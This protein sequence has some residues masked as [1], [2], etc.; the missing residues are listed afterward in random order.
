MNLQ[1]LGQTIKQK[2]P[3]YNNIDDTV[4]ANKILEKYPEYQSK[5]TVETTKKPEQST[6]QKVSSFVPQMSLGVAKGAG[7]TLAGASSLGE[8]TLKGIGRIIT[9]KS[10]EEKLGFAKSPTGAESLG[11]QEKLKPTN[12]AQKIGFGVEQVGE[13]LVPGAT[14]LKVGKAIQGARTLA[15]TPKLAKVAG[16]AGRSLTE[17]GLFG[18]Q[19][20][21]Q[22]GEI[23]DEAKRAALLGGAF[24]VVGT[25]LKIVGQGIKKSTPK[26]A[27][28]IINSMI[29]P[30]MKDLSYE[31]NP[32]RGLLKYVEPF[33][34]F[35]QGMKNTNKSLKTLKDEMNV[36]LKD[37]N[38]LS[39]KIS[40]NKEINNIF[41]KAIQDAAKKNEKTLINRLIENKKAI[42]ENLSYGVNELTG[43]EE[44]ISSGIKNLTK[45]NPQE[46]LELKQIVGEMRK[47]TGN[48]SEDTVSNKSIGKVYGILKEKFIEAGKKHGYDFKEISEGMSDLITAKKVMEYRDKLQSRQNLIN[49]P[50][51]IGIG[52]GAIA[53]IFTGGLSGILA[54][55]TSIGADKVLSSPAFKTRFAKWLYNA[56][57]KEKETLIS[58]F[59]PLKSFIDRAIGGKNNTSKNIYSQIHKDTTTAITTKID[60]NISSIIPKN[61][62]LSRTLSPKFTT[63]SLSPK[64]VKTD[65]LTT[66]IQKAKAEGKSF[67]EWV[68]VKQIDMI[69]KSNPM[70]DDYHTGIRTVKDIKTFR[71]AIDDPESFSYPDF[72]KQKAQQAL[73]NGKITIYSSKEL[74]NPSSQFVSPSKMNATDYAGGNN[75]YSRKVNVD[76]VAWL[77][78]DEGQFIGETKS[79]L[80]VKWD[81]AQVNKKRSLNNL[82]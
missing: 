34:N 57:T 6:L 39:E 70:T 8:K 12:T 21:L 45:L 65:P 60:K 29:K 19:T 42:T 55:I 50:G 62:N 24:P 51:K 40:V 43:K 7:S 26:V 47:W 46:V 23:G 27:E 2:Y 9:P 48:V 78:G 53:S 59:P 61:K 81:K 68:K 16:L 82:K 52:M 72:N 75:V 41:N 5:I 17:A 33:N 38:L 73:D 64:T 74:N 56:S 54:G 58:K 30:L 11:L 66:S 32:S 10:M 25:G 31:K 76:D 37:K 28:K 3:Q 15:G 1:E 36:N 79:Q 13:F 35:E 44:I 77:N 4:L 71:E 80:K 69:N 49:L 67:D 63:R 18:G 14:S 22:Q 20:A